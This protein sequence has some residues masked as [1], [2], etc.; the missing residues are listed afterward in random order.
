MKALLAQRPCPQ[1]GATA[2]Q[3][4]HDGRYVLPDGH[5][6]DA[7]VRVVVCERCGFCFSDTPSTRADFDRYYRDV[8]KYAD[9]SL[10]SGAGSSREDKCRLAETAQAIDSFAHTRDARLVDIGCGAG[11][12]LDSLSDRGFHDLTGVDPAAAC[13][14]EVSRRGH[15]GVVG[16][17]DNHPL[18]DASFDGVILSHVLEHVHD[19]SS[20]LA[21]AARLL[22]PAGWLY[23]E[24]PDAA[25]Y[26]EC[27]IAP[28]QDFNLEHINHFSARTLR[29]VLQCHGWSVASEGG[30]TLALPQ[31]RGYPAVYAFARVGPAEPVDP[32]RSLRNALS[33]YAATSSAMVARIDRLLQG[34]VGGERVL[35]WGVGQLTM[36]LLG[37]TWLGRANIAAFIDS[38][39]IH[40]GRTLAGKPVIS[41]ESLANGAMSDASIIIGSLV[42]GESIEASIRER[43]LAQRVIRLDATRS[44]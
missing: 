25:R 41:P 27:L 5:P 20:A 32:D 37:A 8:S 10:S 16:T 30:K 31:G 15:D 7:A 14:R 12:L 24:V 44:A 9:A 4:V 17:F 34:E 40:H 39:P 42:N 1:C 28:F 11:G 13:A 19:I 18:A 36:R 38:N 23:V 3:V 6:L 33:E 26:G 35:V 29:N 22:R 2:V 43:G 21:A